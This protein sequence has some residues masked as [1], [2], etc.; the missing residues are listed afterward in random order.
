MQLNSHVTPTAT[1]R[2]NSVQPPSTT[3]PATARTRL[4]HPVSH[5]LPFSRVG[6]NTDADV[7]SH[8]TPTATPRPNSVQSPSTIS[9]A[10]KLAPVFLAW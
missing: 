4:L 2:P 1:P 7:N 9:P 3:S 10:A 6:E 5:P 8:V